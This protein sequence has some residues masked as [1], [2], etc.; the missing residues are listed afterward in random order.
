M[1]FDDEPSENERALVEQ[2]RHDA[3][4]F[5]RLYRRYLPRVHAYALR[6]TGDR[7]AAEDITSATF[8]AVVRGLPDFRWKRGG[9]GAWVFRIAANQVVAHYRREARPRSDRGQAAM[10]TFVAA[11]A[12]DADLVGAGSGDGFDDLRAAMARLSPRY[13]Q[14]ISLRYL[15]DLDHDEAAQ[16]MGL[17][18]PAFAVVLSRARKALRR[19]LEREDS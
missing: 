3:D 13:Q 15:S 2:A 7:R 14:A 17:A 18:G 19:E 11:T 10:S 16:A 5:A 12:A 6:R 9:F 8:E 4:A 1:G